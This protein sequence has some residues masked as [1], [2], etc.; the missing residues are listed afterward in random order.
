M[1]VS[2]CMTTDVQI[3]DP[4]HTLRDVASM[5]GRLDAGVLPVGENDRLVGMI[6]DRDIAIRGVAEGKGPDAKVRDVMSTDV[7]YCFDDEDIEDVLHNMGDLQVRRL[8]V[9]NRSKRLVGIISLGDLAMMGETME[10]GKALSD[11][12]QRGGAHSQTP[13]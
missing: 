13:H 8:P 12:S 10:T 1:K 2:D 3:T 11:I 7:K 4:E 5:M 6:T 9:L